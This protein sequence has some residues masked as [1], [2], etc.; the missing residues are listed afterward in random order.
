MSTRAR[1]GGPY[2]FVLRLDTRHCET[3]RALERPRGKIAGSLAEEQT[4]AREASSARMARQ[5][6]PD[7]V[8]EN[9]TI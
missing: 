8:H 2:D 9:E 5:V 6:S 3:R 4:P 1:Q 7:S